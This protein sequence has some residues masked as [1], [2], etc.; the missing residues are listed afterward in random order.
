MTAV[1][2]TPTMMPTHP[3]LL[4][5]SQ[6]LLPACI[7]NPSFAPP[8][9]VRRSPCHKT[10]SPKYDLIEF[11]GSFSLHSELPGVQ[12][13]DIK[14]EFTDP[15]T[16]TIRGRS[17]RSYTSGAPPVGLTEGSITRGAIPKASKSHETAVKDE[18]VTKKETC[19][20]TPQPLQAEMPEE[21]YWL[22]ERST[23]E[24]SQ[25]FIFH[26]RVNQDHVQA[27][28]KNG[29]LSIVVLKAQKR[30]SCRI[31]IS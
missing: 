15:Q 28:I 30:E 24:F 21:K 20:D 22:S 6:A 14:I 17:E 1:P 3:T 16:M 18:S 19:T 8:L 12:Q 13:D 23:R 10:F 9:L 27:L 4:P 26:V 25:S 2:L 29:L 5:L 31:D 7:L 11:S